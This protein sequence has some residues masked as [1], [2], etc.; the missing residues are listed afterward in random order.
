MGF[1]YHKRIKVAPGVNLNMAKH[2]ASSLSFG[3]NNT[4]LNFE[5]NNP[6][7]AMK[8]L[9]KELFNHSSSV[10]VT[11]NRASEKAIQLEQILHRRDHC[12]SILHISGHE[13]NEDLL[14][15]HILPSKR[16]TQLKKLNVM[17]E[18]TVKIK[19]INNQILLQVSQIIRDYQLDDFI[20]NY[21]FSLNNLSEYQ[22]ALIIYIDANEHLSKTYRK[23]MLKNTI[24]EFENTVYQ[25]F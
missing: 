18:E 20:A 3:K 13:I 24:I 1:R 4:E 14:K 6:K 2:G 17:V 16:R 21:N 9:Q 19:T 25:R 11:N 8:N 5:Q 23:E 7:M 12:I 15:K 22:S 10:N